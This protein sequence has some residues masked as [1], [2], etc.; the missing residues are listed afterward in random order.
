MNQIL[1]LVLAFAGSLFLSAGCVLQWLGHERVG[2]RDPGSWRVARDAY[3]WFGMGASTLGT[4]LHYAAIWKGFLSLVL[5]VS[6]LHIAITALAMSRL[7]KEAVMGSRALGI[8]LVALGV[9]ACMVGEAGAVGSDRL[10][11]TGVPWISAIIGGVAVLSL[12]IPRQGVRLA[13]GSGIAY[14]LAAVAVKALSGSSDLPSKLVAVAVFLPA[15]AG[16]FF[17]I[18]AGFRRGGAGSVN[19]MATGTATALAMVAAVVVFHEPV[20]VLSWIGAGCIALGVAFSGR[21]SKV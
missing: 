18:Q 15:Y 1:S 5:P 20:P 16:G 8:S 11:R 4:L 13:V 9:L 7:R 3:W 6:S 10:D 19:A 12:L 17:L 21:R 14:A 2:R